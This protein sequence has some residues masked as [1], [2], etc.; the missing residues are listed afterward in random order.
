MK[1]LVWQGFPH[2]EEYGNWMPH[3]GLVRQGRDGT[4]LIAQKSVHGCTFFCAIEPV[5]VSLSLCVVVPFTQE[6]KHGPGSTTL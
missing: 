4:A 3:I 1:T 2:I 5:F 6:E